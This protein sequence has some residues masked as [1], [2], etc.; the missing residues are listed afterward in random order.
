MERALKLTY[1]SDDLSYMG[2]G[3][4]GYGDI[5]LL[6]VGCI[7]LLLTIGVVMF[8][9][10]VFAAGASRLSS[11]FGGA[12]SQ[13]VEAA[14]ILS[15]TLHHLRENLHV[16]DSLSSRYHN[17]LHGAGWTAVVDTM[18]DLSAAEEA[19]KLLVRNRRYDEAFGLAA[20]LLDE[21]PDDMAN[22]AAE[23]FHEFAHLQSW[24]D[25][26]RAQLITIIDRAS[27]AAKASKEVGIDHQINGRATLE[28]L[29]DLRKLIDS[30]DNTPDEERS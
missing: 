8:F 7:A 9:R 23:Q 30:Q 29:A 19:T 25:R 3:Q 22:V 1:G 20:F 10:H 11:S 16:L 17:A 28:T 5:Q 15:N 24:Q 14:E 4:T 21:L 2:F 13:A 6:G 12:K 27:E 18:N 26:L